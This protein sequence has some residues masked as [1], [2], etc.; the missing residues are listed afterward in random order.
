[1]GWMY[2]WFHP[3]FSHE[4]CWEIII[5]MLLLDSWFLLIFS[6]PFS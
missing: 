3:I 4:M 6:Q 5:S 1:L 2:L